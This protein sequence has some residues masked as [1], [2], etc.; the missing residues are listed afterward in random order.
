MNHLAKKY[1]SFGKMTSP[2][3]QTQIHEGSKLVH[4]PS[5]LIHDLPKPT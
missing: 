1:Y 2:K 5:K 3:V 4:E